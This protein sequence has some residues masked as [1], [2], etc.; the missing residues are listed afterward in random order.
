MITVILVLKTIGFYFL[1][2]YLGYSSGLIVR[3]KFKDKPL[4]IRIIIS[5]LLSIILVTILC[6]ITQDYLK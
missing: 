2:F 4:F 5:L 6:F 3:E 1:C